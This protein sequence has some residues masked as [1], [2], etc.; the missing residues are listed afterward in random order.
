MMSAGDVRQLIPIEFYGVTYA[1]LPD[2]LVC[3]FRPDGFPGLHGK[4]IGYSPRHDYY[5]LELDDPVVTVDPSYNKDGYLALTGS[6]VAA[7]HG[8]VA[9]PH[10]SELSQFDD[11]FGKGQE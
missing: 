11:M 2:D 9:L 7:M 3:R 10:S 1:E 4:I 5:L 6:F 8:E